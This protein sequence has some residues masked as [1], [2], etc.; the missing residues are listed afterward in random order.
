MVSKF[1]TFFL[2]LIILIF[3]ILI[4]R[5]TF[6]TEY[7]SK[8]P[9]SIVIPPAQHIRRKKKI[10][11]LHLSTPNIQEY[12]RHSVKNI[13]AYAEKHDYG[14]IVYDKIIFPDVPP[15]WNKICAILH[16]LNQYE[17]IIW[18]DA[19]AIITNFDTTLE[20]IITPHQDYDLLVCLD[21]YWQVQCI[22]SGVMMVKNT[23]WTKQLFTKVWKN[24]APHE[25]NDQNVLF[26]EI[27]N[28]MHPKA[29]SPLFW[30]DYCDKIQHP[31]VKI[32]PETLF[33]TH[34]RNFQKGHFVLHL[35]GLSTEVRVDVMRQFNTQL[36]IDDYHKRDCYDVLRRPVRAER[37]FPLEKK[38]LGQ[39]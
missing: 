1:L 17:W 21:I 26:Q 9:F 24:P 11:L 37:I 10:A 3:S 39:H 18:I 28:E 13:S 15:C 16:N 32:F 22:N 25:L 36:G 4:L 14:L 27:V 33:N 5:N 12:A 19:D 23:Q 20:S 31:K 7:F 35:M 30:T 6:S 8:N 34:I 29:N 38:C 2:I